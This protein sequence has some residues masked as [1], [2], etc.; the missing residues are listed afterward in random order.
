MSATSYGPVNSVIIWEFPDG[1]DVDL[2]VCARHIALPGPGLTRQLAESNPR[3][4]RVS[5]VSRTTLGVGLNITVQSCVDTLGGFGRQA[6]EELSS[7]PPTSC[8]ARLA[9]GL[10]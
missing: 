3:M 7:P 4:R 8:R 2:N 5:P 1:P 10:R 6:G 9:D